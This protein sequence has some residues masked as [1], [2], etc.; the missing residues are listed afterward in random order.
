MVFLGGAVLAVTGGVPREGTAGP[1]EAGCCCQVEAVSQ[2]LGHI[3]VCT[4]AVTCLAM[5]FFTL[6]EHSQM[7]V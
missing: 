6:Q 5:L 1:G 4:V 2:A 7:Y 3:G